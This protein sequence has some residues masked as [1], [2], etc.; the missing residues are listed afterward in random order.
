V[1]HR[2]TARASLGQEYFEGYETRFTVYAVHGEGQPQSFA[3]GSSDLEGDGFFGRHLLYVPDGPA[4]PNVVFA[5]S[6]QV[7]EFFDWVGRQGLSPGFVD[8]N[9]NHASWSTRFDVGVHQDFPI[10]GG[11]KGRGFAKIYNFGNFLNDDW[12]KIYDAPFFTPQVV[13]SSVDDE[14]RYVF[15]DFDEQ[16]VTDLLE[17][18]TLWQARFG[19]E[20]RF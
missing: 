8:R 6:F 5:D 16:S 4:D 10:F 17:N 11:V 15:E 19:L 9:G 13:D 14:G 7:Q 2:F 1:P 18:A 12:G 20:I 3:M